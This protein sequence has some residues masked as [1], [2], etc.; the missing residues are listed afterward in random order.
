MIKTLAASLRRWAGRS[1]A[2][3]AAQPLVAGYR[4]TPPR[5]LRVLMF[6]ALAIAC[7]AYG[8]AFAIYAP[9]RVMPFT[10][11]AAILAGLLLWTLPPGEYAPTPLLEPLFLAFFA[12]LVLW[13][14][15]LAITLGNLPWMTLMRLTGLPL[16]ITLL[17]CISISRPFREKLSAILQADKVMFRLMLVLIALW[18]GSILLSSDPGTTVNRY[19]LAVLN[20]AGI[21]FVSCYLFSRRGF[22]DIWVRMLLVMLAILC[23]FAVWEFRLQILPWVGHIPSFLTVDDPVVQKILRPTFNT[24]EGNYRVKASATT[25]LGL[26]ELLGLS[27]PFTM[28]FLIGRHP[29]YL[30]VAAGIFLP[31]TA[32]VILLT[33]SRLGVVAGCASAMFYLLIWGA[34]RW[35]QRKESL[36]APALVLSYPA[37]FAAFIAATFLVDKLR[38]KFW[39]RGS[40]QAS[41]QGRIDQWELG[42]PKVIANPIGHGVG[43]GADALGFTNLAGDLTID[44]YWLS[45]LLEIGVA[46][47]I[48]FYGLML[49][50]AFTAARTV[51]LVGPEREFGLLLPMSVALINFVIVKSVF[52]QEANHPL[53]FMILGAVVALTYRA[54]QVQ[55]LVVEAANPKRR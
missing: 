26:A 12:A 7:I 48:V 14:N 55:P 17:A 35:R 50:G 4:R 49:R 28:H 3:L 40:Q 16:V 39:G 38:Y 18:T 19:F 34:L 25:P 15:Y 33:D 13:P 54:A 22:A 51:V 11:P 44:S 2:E 27:M 43:Q 1:Q 53:V 47:F 46:G 41:T 6:S 9:A 24:I 31:I 10:I 37:I 21:F 20:Y 30:R 23:A 32:Y 8:Y 45:V 52:S 29:L 36:F 5:L 42:I